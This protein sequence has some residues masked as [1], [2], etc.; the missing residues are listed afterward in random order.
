MAHDE[1]REVVHP[2]A[3][4]R[5]QGGAAH[6]AFVL[7]TDA[8]DEVR[9]FEQL[10]CFQPVDE[11]VEDGLDLHEHERVEVR[12]QAVDG[13]HAVGSGHDGHGV[14]LLG[15]GHARIGAGSG[16]GID[17][18]DDLHLHAR[19]EPLHGAGQMAK[20]GVGAG[21]ALDEEEHVQ[22][23]CE[24]GQHGVGGLEPG[25]CEL[26]AV[27]RHGKQQ[28]AVGVGGRQAGAG[29]DVERIARRLA[30]AGRVHPGAVAALER[31][32]GSAGDEARIARAERHTDE[33]AQGLAGS[34]GRQRRSCCGRRRC[35]EGH[36]WGSS[37]EAHTI[38]TGFSAAMRCM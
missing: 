17:A 21:I 9:T 37:R 4:Q 7:G 22:P 20:G 12:Q 18:G 38:Q 30:A 15:E 5:A 8:L 3:A 29:D 19:I 35:G 10:A 33:P 28:Q 23:R 34:A 32:P 25:A 13:A 31:R 2:G 24:P 1:Q 26:F 36:V 11:L 16:E 27:V 6:A 14:V